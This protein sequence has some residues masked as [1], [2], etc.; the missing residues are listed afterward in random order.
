MYALVDEAEKVIM[1]M[2]DIMYIPFEFENK[3]MRVICY[4]LE[5]YVER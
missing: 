1:A 2:K 4:S 3:G 5:E